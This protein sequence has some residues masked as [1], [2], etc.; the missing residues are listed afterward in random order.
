MRL[1]LDKQNSFRI[2]AVNLMTGSKPAVVGVSG[3]HGHNSNEPAPGTTPFAEFKF[4]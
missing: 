1:N 3:R 2:R 4:F